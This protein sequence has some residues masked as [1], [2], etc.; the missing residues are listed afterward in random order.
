MQTNVLSNYVHYVFHRAD[1]TSADPARRDVRCFANISQ[2]RE[3]KK[4]KYY[5]TEITLEDGA[6]A[7]IK[8]ARG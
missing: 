3:R 2:G 8:V 1:A 4:T 7:T 5:E 6:K